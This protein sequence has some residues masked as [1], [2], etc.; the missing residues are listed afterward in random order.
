MEDVLP[1]AIPG[2]EPPIEAKP[3]DNEPSAAKVDDG[4]IPGIMFEKPQTRESEKPQPIKPDHY[5]DGGRVPVFKPVM[6][7]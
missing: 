1:E 7:T 4:A 3:I 6:I 2:R 5:W